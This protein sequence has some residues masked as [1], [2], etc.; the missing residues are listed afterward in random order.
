MAEQ[1]ANSL[2]RYPLARQVHG[3]R[4]AQTVRSSTPNRQCVHVIIVPTVALYT[5]R[6]CASDVTIGR[7]ALGRDLQAGVTLKLTIR[8]GSPDMQHQLRP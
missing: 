4:V 3:Q 7:G 5:V 2:E 6:R 1:V 8:K